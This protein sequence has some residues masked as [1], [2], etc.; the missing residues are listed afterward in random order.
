MKTPLLSLI[1][2]PLVACSG[3]GDPSGDNEKSDCMVS[4]SGPVVGSAKCGVTTTAWGSSNNVGT[5]SFTVTPVGTDPNVGVVVKWTG[6]P[7]VGQVYTGSD[8]GAAE[9][10]ATLY[11]STGAGWGVYIGGTGPGSFP[12]AAYTLTFSSVTSPL[13][14][15][16]GAKLYT[17]SGSLE[18]TLVPLT[19][20]GGA[21]ETLHATF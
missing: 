3:T 13:D 10:G 20:Q 1:V 12:P 2:I 16:T 15:G 14:T 8:P 5:F 7:V 18:A 9:S 6:Q 19:G 11:D 4:Y 17:A 21:N